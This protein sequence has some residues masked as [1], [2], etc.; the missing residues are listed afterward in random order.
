MWYNRVRLY[1]L[2]RGYKNN[3]LCPCVFI[4]NIESGF[5]TIEV[6]VDD[7]KII[8]TSREI[9][10]TVGFLKSEFEMKNLGKTKFCLGLELE[11]RPER[12]LV[13]QTAYT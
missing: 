5:A 10:E 1:L 13:H 4:R 2:Q 3:N 8:S 7:M 12:F 9:E 11:H 6:Y